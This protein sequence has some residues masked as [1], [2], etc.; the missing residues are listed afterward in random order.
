[1]T[2]W[3]LL[4]VL[5][6]DIA[7]HGITGANIIPEN[8][9]RN[10]VN[11]LNV[12]HEWKYIDYDFGSDERRQNA[13][14]SGEY[15]HTKNYPFDIDQWHDKIFITVIRYDGVPSSLNIISDKIGNGGRLLQPYPD[16][17]WTNY[18]DCSGIVSVYRIAIDKFDRLWV[19]DSGLVNNTQHMC[20]PK[21]LAFDLNTSHLLKQIHVPHDIAVN[22]TTGKGGL[23]FLAV[24][25]VDP[26][27]TMVYMSDNRG[28]ALI[29]YQNSDDSFHR[30]TSNTFDYDPRYIKMTIEGESLTLEDGIFGIAVSPVTNNLY[31]SPLSSHGLYYVNT[32]PF[33]KSQYGGNDVQY[34]G[35]ED[36]YNTQLSA[37]AVSKNGVLFFGLV[38]N[39]AVGCLN[40]HQ[41]IQRQ[42]I[43][44]VAQNKETLQMIIAMKILEDLQQFGKINRTQRNEY[45]L[46]LSNRIQKIVN[47]DF[48][49]DEINFRILKANVN[50][51]IR[52]TR[53]ANNDIQN[54][55]K[56]NN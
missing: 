26:I 40:E 21:L 32:E 52:N 12:I 36:I 24:Q 33:M 2:S 14:Q 3:L 10:L 17:S 7:C 25:A 48:N 46:V 18:K 27:N 9:S 31:Y 19:L 45:M 54:N 15:D 5:S 11:S 53:C 50:D 47:N 41:Q 42:N 6:V 34:N 56:N 39:S 20:S 37:K 13:I 44:M 55:N 43:N 4:V 22:A 51:L 1:M 16:W 28:N 30:L 49:F 29:I 23:V 8:S 35:V 38:H